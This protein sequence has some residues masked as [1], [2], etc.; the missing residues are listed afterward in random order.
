MIKISFQKNIQRLGIACAL[1][2]T[3][4]FADEYRGSNRGV[5]YTADNSTAANH[6]LIF[7][8]SASGALSPGG[9]VATGGTGTGAGLGNQSALAMQDDSRLLFVVNA[10]SNE[11]SVLAE[12][13]H[14][15]VLV[16]K[17]PSGGVRP[18]SVTVSDDLVYVLNAGGPGSPDNIS[19]FRVGKNGRLKP[20]ADSTRPL[21]AA[22][23]GPAQIAFN[24]EGDVLLVTEKNTNTLTT[25]TIGED[26]RA[27]SQQSVASHGAT[28]FGF[29]FSGRAKV[30]VTNAAGGAPGASS[31]SSY[32]LDET[33]STLN[34]ANA[35]PTNQAAACWVAITDNGRLGF[36][37]NTASNS[38]SRFGIGSLGSLTLLENVTTGGLATPIDVALS[39]GDRFLYVLNAGSGATRS[40]SAFAVGENGSLTALTGAAGLPVGSNGLIAR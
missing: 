19:G 29:A 18:V 10:G 39:S 3:T 5:V 30:F 6:V 24:P 20:L 15:L 16:D 27:I 12:T 11:L 2:A 23:T 17:E 9:S 4:A 13:R 1:I 33:G 37:S 7:N 35:V 34:L 8:R 21:S 26:G 36:V 40:I 32:F 31:M 38:V 14:G 28:P 25:F 22:G